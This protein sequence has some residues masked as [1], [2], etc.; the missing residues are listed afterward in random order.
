MLKTYQGVLDGDRIEWIG[1]APPRPP[2]KSK[3]RVHVTLLDQVVTDEDE[4]ARGRRRAEALERLAAR[5]GVA[6]IPDPD[7]WQREMREDR[8]LPGRDE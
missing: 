5:G 3:V 1:E 2:D 6:S 4:A 8:P 7:A